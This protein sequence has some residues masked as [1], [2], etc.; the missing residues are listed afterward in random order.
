[1]NF[2]LAAA[3]LNSSVIF[4]VQLLLQHKTDSWERERGLDCHL[5]AFWFVDDLR[6]GRWLS[7]GKLLP[8][9]GWT[10]TGVGKSLPD[11]REQLP[12][13]QPSSYSPP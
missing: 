2:N 8:A 6:D 1:M 7:S 10:P 13:R 3:I 12:M 4:I 9:V 5:G 11:C